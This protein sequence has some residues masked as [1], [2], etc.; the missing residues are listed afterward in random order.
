MKMTTT[1]RMSRLEYF[2]AIAKITSMRGTCPRAKVG[3]VAVKDNR[4]I[5]SAYNGSVSGGKHCTDV[6]CLIVNNHCIRTVHAEMNIITECAKA[7]ISLKEATIYCT[8][9]PCQNCL[10]SLI[11]AGVS[12]IIFNEEKFDDKVNEE[13]YHLVN[14]RQICSYNGELL[15][16]EVLRCNND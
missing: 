6:G 13:L 10:K 11:S 8:L 14:L 5:M 12:T 1:A 9:E 4:I 2:M 7:G 16:K 3:A 15:T